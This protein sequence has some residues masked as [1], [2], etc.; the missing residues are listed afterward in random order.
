MTRK[1]PSAIVVLLLFSVLAMGHLR[2]EGIDDLDRLEKAIAQQKEINEGV[3]ERIAADEKAIEE[4]RETAAEAD[5]VRERM[6]EVEAAFE[7]KQVSLFEKE[8]EFR[9][10]EAIARTYREQFEPRYRIEAGQ[11]FE[12][13]GNFREVEILGKTTTGVNFRH[14][15]GLGSFA[16]E[17]LPPELLTESILAPQTR[18]AFKLSSAE[19]LALRPTLPGVAGEINRRNRMQQE[20][21][22]REEKERREAEKNRLRAE[23][24]QA[25]E[26]EQREKRERTSR[27][28]EHNEQ[29]ETSMAEIR[30]QLSTLS[31]RKLQAMSAKSEEISRFHAATIKPDAKA[32]AQTL[33]RFDEQILAI[34]KKSNELEAELR[35]LLTQMKPE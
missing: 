6:E 10:L 34:E 14:A 3:R 33:A 13:L 16:F 2:G 11:R 27:A 17:E 9:A 28:R 20:V 7:E 24:E 32:H 35:R 8:D 5:R 23:Q 1:H 15:N 4:N 21:K 22:L 29:I 31:T 26:A 25:R 18:G 30:A 12:S 19:L